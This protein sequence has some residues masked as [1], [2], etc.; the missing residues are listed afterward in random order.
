VRN[1]KGAIFFDSGGVWADAWSFNSSGIESG[2]GVGLRL[3]LPIGPI[4]LDYGYGINRGKGRV[5][6]TGGWNF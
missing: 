3:N 1:I 2:V 6:F 5:H 4:R